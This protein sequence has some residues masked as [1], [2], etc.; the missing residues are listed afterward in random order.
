MHLLTYTFLSLVSFKIYS[1]N[2][3]YLPFDTTSGLRMLSSRHHFFRT[4]EHIVNDIFPY[5]VTSGWNSRL[6]NRKWY[7]SVKRYFRHEKP[8][9]SYQKWYLPIWRHFW[10]KTNILKPEVTWEQYNV[11]LGRKL[12]F[13]N[14]NWPFFSHKP[15]FRSKIKILKKKL[16]FPWLYRLFT[17][18]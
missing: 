12:R 10:L 7:Q 9:F 5:Y 8:R 3:L 11:T 1:R 18:C 4:K 2:K 17:L 13:W 16:L 6:W 14:R 15:Q